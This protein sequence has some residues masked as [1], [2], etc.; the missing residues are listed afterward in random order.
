MAVAAVLADS[1]AILLS[2]WLTPWLV[3]RFASPSTGNAALLVGLYL[4]FCLAVYLLR[5]SGAVHADAAAGTV[6]TVPAV[7][8]G[9]M[10]AYMAASSSGFSVGSLMEWDLNSLDASAAAIGV[11][12]LALLTVF[13]YM[14]VLV[15]PTRPAAVA[16]GGAAPAERLAMLLGTNLMLIAS[17]AHWEAHFAGVDVALT[18]SGQVLVFLGVYALVALFFG[19]PR[20]LVARGGA[21]PVPVATFLLQAAYY[22]WGFVSRMAW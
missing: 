20:L 15:V 3:H 9:V 6:A 7:I 16:E 12:V 17:I 5:R 10:V 13:L 19:G 22:V 1:S 4:A 18:P 21:G 14:F 8:F 2:F 11:L